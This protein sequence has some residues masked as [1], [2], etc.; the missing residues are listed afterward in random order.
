MRSLLLCVGLLVV[1]APVLASAQQP[2]LGAIPRAEPEALGFSSERLARL[3][4]ALDAYVDEGKLPGYQLVVARFGKVAHARSYGAMD[5]E[6]ER[7]LEPDTIFRI[8]SMSKVVTGIATLIAYEQGLFLLSDPVS[9][10]IP[11]LAKL[12]V[13]DPE[14]GRTRPARREITVLDLLRHTSGISYSFNAPGD[15]GEQ[16]VALSLTPGIRGL[17]D[18]AGLGPVG[19]D[20]Q[21]TLADMVERLGSLPL[22]FEPGTAWHYGINQDVLGRLIEVTSGRSFPEFLRTQLF[23]PL[24]MHDSGFY[25]P[26]AKLSRFANCYG[27]TP[28]GG[29]RLLDTAGTSEYRVPPAMP[30]GGGGMVSSTRDYLRFA[31]MLAGGGALDGRRV[32]GRKTVDLA[33]SNHLPQEVFGPGPLGAAASRSYGNDGLGVR[34]G[35]TGSVITRP[36]LTGLPVSKG[37]FGW[38]GAASTFFWVDPQEDV[39]VVFMTQLVLSGSYPLRAQLYTLVNAALID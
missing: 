9:K 7:A 20:Q 37:T 15:L 28:E 11:A 19:E 4:E 13:R 22:L 24:G 26:D 1:V 39:A 21:A 6:A 38:G 14:T 34:F 17:P 2:E 10:Y 8:Y 16:Y 23:A 27:P 5:V 32:L 36:A 3:D 33:M 30:G 12:Q 25:V 31:L 29:M 35:L 18:D